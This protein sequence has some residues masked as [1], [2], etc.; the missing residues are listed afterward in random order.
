MVQFKQFF[1]AKSFYTS[2]NLH[3]PSE[4]LVKNGCTNINFTVVVNEPPNYKFV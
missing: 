2:I 3:Q 4:K 1:P